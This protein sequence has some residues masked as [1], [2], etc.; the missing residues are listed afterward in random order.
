MATPER[1]HR[2]LEDSDEE[3][4]RIILSNDPGN[5]PFERA[6]LVLDYRNLD[7]Q[8]RATEA[9]QRSAE[10][11]VEAAEALGRFT[12]RLMF[13]TWALV[14]VTAVLVVATLLPWVAA[15]LLP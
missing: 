9:L 14:A 1:Q 10:R 8:T 4:L 3:L 12:R 11:Q 15:W 7:R 6:R 2:Y 13:A 5:P